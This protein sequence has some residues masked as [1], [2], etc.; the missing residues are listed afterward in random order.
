MPLPSVH[1]HIPLW[2][3]CQVC[4]GVLVCPLR[5]APACVPPYSSLGL[6][7]VVVDLVEAARARGLKVAVCSGGQADVV[8][9]VV[10]MVLSIQ[11]D[12][13]HYG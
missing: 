1:A 11:D 7:P 13:Y 4:V 8:Q 9:Q 5:C 10:G 3:V 12:T 2:Y 6:V